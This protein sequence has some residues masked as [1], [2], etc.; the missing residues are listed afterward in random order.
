MFKKFNSVIIALIKI[1]WLKSNLYSINK[2]FSRTSFLW[3]KYFWLVNPVQVQWDR[4]ICKW[5]NGWSPIHYMNQRTAVQVYACDLN[6]FYSRMRVKMT[7][8]YIKNQRNFNNNY[9][10][11]LKKFR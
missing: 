6:Q 5:K 10:I 2:S 3:V 1:K 11:F 9:A 8:K 7:Q 4:N